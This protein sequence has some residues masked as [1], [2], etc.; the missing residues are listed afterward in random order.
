ML[1]RH[2]EATIAE[3]AGACLAERVSLLTFKLNTSSRSRKE[4][5]TK[6][7]AIVTEAS[8]VR[9]ELYYIG[10]AIF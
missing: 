6:A 5:H 10:A 2:F 1:S 9:I 3:T 8:F 4:W 7:A